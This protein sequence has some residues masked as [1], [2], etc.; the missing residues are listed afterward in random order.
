MSTT[1]TVT[2]ITW[3]RSGESGED[4]FR[5][6]GV[7]CADSIEDLLS[8]LKRTGWA[9]ASTQKVRDE[10]GDDYT[11]TEVVFEFVRRRTDILG[12][13]TQSVNGA[14]PHAPDDPADS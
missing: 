4:I 7:E 2:Y 10:Q 3:Y 12:V 8:D 11:E 1:L 13:S 9:L 5:S 14:K 6:D